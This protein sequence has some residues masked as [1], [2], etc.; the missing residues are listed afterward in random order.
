MPIY[1]SPDIKRTYGTIASQ[2]EDFDLIIACDQISDETLR[3]VRKLEA[4]DSRVT[5]IYPEEE[6]LYALKNICRVLDQ[7]D[8]FKIE[9]KDII[10]IID[11]DDYLLR[12]DCIHK[13]LIY[14]APNTGAAW[15]AC[16]WVTHNNE[17]F[18]DWYDQR[19]D[20]Y[21]H[22]WVSSHFR[23]F[24][25]DIYK[26]IPKENFL[27]ED[28]EYFKR[29]YDQALMLPI[30]HKCNELG[31]L[32]HYIEDVMYAYTGDF[33]VGGEGHIYQMKLEQYIRSRGFVNS[34]I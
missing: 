32:T 11:G 6:R 2:D 25:Y 16:S 22:P 33:E 18:S 23:T 1:G 8:F 31:L 10:G 3:L 12:Q 24:R 28:G 14:Y 27:Y 5:A 15:S 19:I 20:P 34:N 9:D 13:F 21:K 26:Q 29:T 4:Y 17:N 7:P 30:L